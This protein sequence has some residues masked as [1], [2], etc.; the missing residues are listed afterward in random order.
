MNIPK[1]KFSYPTFIV[2]GWVR[3]KIINPKTQPKDLDLCMVVD[4]FEKME[5]AILEVG[6]EIYLSTPKYRTIR[7]KI[8]ELGAVDFAMARKDGEYSDGRRPDSTDI[9]DNIID[10][11]SRRDFSSG[12]IA[13]NIQTGEIIDPFEGVKDIENKILRCV[14]NAKNR[15]E[16]DMLRLLRAIRFSITKDFEMSKEIKECLN[17]GGLVYGLKTVSVERIYEEMYKCFDFDTLKTLSML[18]KYPFVRDLV[19]K[20]NMKL[21]PSLKS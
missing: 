6:G 15:F 12:A 21:L 4:S 13:I 7:C 14:G 10:D 9:A 17:N 19:F 1:I 5:Q 20:E 8:P 3:D 18:E 16:E 2:G 11:L